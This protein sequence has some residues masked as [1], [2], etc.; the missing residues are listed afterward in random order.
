M[1]DDFLRR[2]LSSSASAP[3]R[4]SLFGWTVFILLLIGFAFACWFGSYSIFAHPE[5]PRSYAILQ[6]LKKI[7][8]PARFELTK[9]PTGEFLT[10]QKLYE[11]YNGMS[12]LELE[13][14]NAALLR[15]YLRNYEQTK[16]LVPYIVGRFQI[17]DA[18]PL[19]SKD[20]FTSGSVAVAQA[21][22]YQQVLVELAYTTPAENVPML[23]QILHTGLEVDLKRTLDLSAIIHVEKIY[24]GRLQFTV[25]PL[26]Y[27]RYVMRQGA[28]GFSLEPPASLN[29]IA[30]APLVK[31]DRLQDAFKKFADYRKDKP[32]D[33]GLAASGPGTSAA[34]SELIRVETA[35]PV[36]PIVAS[37][38]HS[39]GHASPTPSA[40]PAALAAATV[41]APSPTLLVANATPRIAPAVPTPTAP[42][43]SAS[44]VKLEPF[45]QAAPGPG[46]GPVRGATWQTY[47]PGKLPPGRTVEVPDATALAE[48]GLG[49]ETMYL[50]GDFVVTASGENQAVLR[51]R[52][53]ATRVGPGSA[54]VMVEFPAGT[55]P[56][57]E[58]SAVARD[59]TRAFRINDVR[60]GSDGS[61]TIYVREVTRP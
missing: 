37:S 41:A 25:L 56:P 51:P 5:T 49:P 15:D 59:D 35:E 16:N 24:D 39:R 55:P 8:P 42:L 23:Q 26:L 48:S 17:L 6:K 14:A 34:P 44:G 40:T 43:V 33:P 32:D 53:G 52:D 58:G 10:P 31:A 19:T 46:L 47:A 11:R 7:A 2:E 18:F 38:K 30:G 61:I 12:R 45:L 36:K 3:P 50:R 22:D 60:R 20:L 9:A 1:D 27:G 54:R 21:A 13:R 29:L 57:E 28:G 4:D